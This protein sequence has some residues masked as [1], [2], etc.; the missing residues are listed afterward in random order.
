MVLFLQFHPGKKRFESDMEQIITT[1]QYIQ[2]VHE[3]LGL[4]HYHLNQDTPEALVILS[5]L[6]VQEDQVLP[7]KLRS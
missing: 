5:L 2:F 1:H 6:L 4:L 3:F 7:K